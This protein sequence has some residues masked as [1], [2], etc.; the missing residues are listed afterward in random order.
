[1]GAGEQ[2]ACASRRSTGTC[3]ESASTDLQRRPTLAERNGSYCVDVDDR[4]CVE[5][6]P[7]SVLQPCAATPCA[8]LSCQDS[9]L[10][11]PSNGDDEALIALVSNRLQDLEDD[12][13]KYCRDHLHLFLSVGRA[14][15]TSPPFREGLIDCLE[16]G[17]PGFGGDENAP[18]KTGFTTGPGGEQL[19]GL[20][21]LHMSRYVH[22]GTP[23]RPAVLRGRGSCTHEQP[24]RHEQDKGGSIRCREP[25]FANELCVLHCVGARGSV[26]DARE[27]LRSWEGSAS[28]EK[29]LQAPSSD[30]WR[31][32]AEIQAI[33]DGES[34]R[35]VIPAPVDLLAFGFFL[36]VGGRGGTPKQRVL[37]A[38]RMSPHEIGASLDIPSDLTAAHLSYLH[39][40]GHILEDEN[41]Q[42]PDH[43]AVVVQRVVVPRRAALDWRLTNLK[44]KMWKRIR[45]NPP[46]TVLRLPSKLP[47]AKEVR[48]LPKL[49][50]PGIVS[51]E[52]Q[53]R[54]WRLTNHG[55]SQLREWRATVNEEHR[56]RAAER[57]SRRIA[58]AAVAVSMAAV[59]SMVADFPAAWE[60]TLDFFHRMLKALA[61]IANK[62]SSFSPDPPA[63]MRG[64]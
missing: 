44:H 7:S 58:L 51:P 14:R 49:E 32:L 47:R 24:K 28:Q 43:F 19:D 33:A 35:A 23:I 55:Q 56:K 17:C 45:Y 9:P 22:Y 39:Q 62:D 5:N 36:F 8:M 27:V 57:S 52:H 2:N 6:E 41:L 21:W 1:M 50:G 38:H 20:C 54:A 10:G 30:T 48:F 60:H 25:A 63:L 46:Y 61:A 13:T 3:G 64:W 37:W 53:G 26:R 4:N 16:P 40:H 31:V 29:S 12:A 42:L 59:V 11:A 34:E 18:R 15:R